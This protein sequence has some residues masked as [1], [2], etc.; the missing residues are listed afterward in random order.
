MR[1]FLE[2]G[3]DDTTV[4]D[5]AEAAGV[6]S[7][8]VFRHFPTKEDLVLTDEFDPVLATRIRATPADRPLIQRIG[9]TLVESLAQASPADLEMMLARLRLG[10]AT[11]ALR[12]RW[13]DNEY[14]TQEV[15][16]EALSDGRHD[17]FRL[18]VVAGSCLAAVTAALI[19]W[20]ES[21]G[22][23]APH[24]LVAQA[25]TILQEES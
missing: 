4:A 15:I 12:A 13:L 25:L 8:T 7:M 11:P 20:A 21:G 17:E 5:V 10:L 14:L 23:G 3:Y 16:V 24:E 6:S 18:R 2:H 19:R 9:D 1:L 22:Q